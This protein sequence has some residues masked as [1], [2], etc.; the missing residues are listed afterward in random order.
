MNNVCYCCWDALLLIQ[1]S[2]SRYYYFISIKLR[3]SVASQHKETFVQLMWSYHMNFTAITSCCWLCKD[4]SAQFCLYIHKLI[5]TFIYI[6]HNRSYTIL[7]HN[8]L[9]LCLRH[10]SYYKL[11]TRGSCSPCRLCQCSVCRVQLSVRLPAALINQNIYTK[12]T[13]RN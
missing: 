9:D 5:R 10:F 13:E 2:F 4:I 8:S 12:H 11:T 3:P 1:W 7:L 6:L